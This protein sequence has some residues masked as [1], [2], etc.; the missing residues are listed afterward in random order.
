MTNTKPTPAYASQP[1]VATWSAVYPRDS[2]RG[3][4]SRTAPVAWICPDGHK[5]ATRTC[6]TRHEG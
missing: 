1:Y 4:A 6:A 5:H 2:V 3:R